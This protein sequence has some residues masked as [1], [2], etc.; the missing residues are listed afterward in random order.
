M[1]C[2]S[3]E[4][5]SFSFFVTKELK[6]EL[7]IYSVEKKVRHR[8]SCQKI[9]KWVNKRII[10]YLFVLF[11]KYQFYVRICLYVHGTEHGTR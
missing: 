1:S 6:S 7:V 10:C 3:V 5:F 2:C 8:E 4:C 11:V 9:T